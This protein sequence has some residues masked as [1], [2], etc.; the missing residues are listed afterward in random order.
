MKLSKRT[1]GIL[2]S[3]SRI[4]ESVVIHPGSD[5]AVISN[6]RDVYAKATVEE[7]FETTISIYNINDFLGVVSLFEDPDIQFLE[8]QAVITDGSKKQIYNY[9]DPSIITQPPKT[10]VNLPSVDVKATLSREDFTTLLK[11]AAVNASNEISFTDGGVEV[12]NSSTNNQFR[13]DNVSETNAT[14]NLSIPI[15]N[16]KMIPDDYDVSIASA[17]LSVFSG[18]SDVTY[19][20]ALK[21]D[22]YFQA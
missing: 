22:G 18:A 20:V 15:E 9:A 13:I 14:Y 17:G 10:G 2:K 21:A 1:M 12:K 7:V 11:A 19:A 6:L 3:F 4:N 16:M 8:K 5:I